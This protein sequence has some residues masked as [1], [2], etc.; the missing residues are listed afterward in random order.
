MEYFSEL[1]PG[2]LLLK[3]SPAVYFTSGGCPC[4]GSR[5][6]RR[7]HPYICNPCSAILFKEDS[8]GACVDF[9]ATWSTF[10]LRCHVV[11]PMMSSLSKY[12]TPARA[13]VTGPPRPPTSAHTNNHSYIFR[14]LPMAH[15]AH[16]VRG[17]LRYES[18]RRIRCSVN[19]LSIAHL[20]CNLFREFVG[21]GRGGE[22]RPIEARAPGCRRCIIQ[23]D[24]DDA[25]VARSFSPCA[26]FCQVLPWYLSRHEIARYLS[27]RCT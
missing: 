2:R 21:H 18:P 17:D 3:L 4:M 5:G 8:R 14:S 15:L 16:R 19:V 9:G 20:S 11:H 6:R 25:A 12:L 24:D 1:S 27:V 23:G 7:A 13:N 10:R 22:V 26:V